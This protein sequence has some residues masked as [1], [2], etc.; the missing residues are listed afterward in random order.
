MLERLFEPRRVAVIG[1]SGRPGQVGTE[2]VRSLLAG[3]R[4]ISVVHP[5]EKTVLGVGVTENIEDLPGDVDLAVVAL[6]AGTAEEACVRAARRG[7]P[8]IVPV[9]GGFSETGETGRALERSLVNAVRAAGGRVL[10]PNTVGLWVPGRGGVDTLFV[11]H[12]RELIS[13]RGCVAFVSQSGSVGVEALGAAAV[14]GYG[15]RAFVSL[16]NKADLDES[17]F[18]AH[19]GDDPGCR[20]IALYLESFRDG[21]RFLDVAGAVSRK[22]PVVILKA[23]ATRAGAGAVA[24]HTGAL[25]GSPLVA[26]GAFRQARI[27]SVDGDEALLDGAKALALCP[28]P[29][30]PRAAFLTPAGGYGVLAADA[31]ESSEGEL[32]LARLSEDCRRRLRE[33]SFPY[34][35]VNNPVDLT[36]S[37]TSAMMVEALRILVA[38]PGV[39]LVLCAAF[40]APPGMSPDLVP[41]IAEVARSAKKPVL[42]LAMFGHET[43]ALCKRFTD[44]GVAAFP[45]LAR[46]VCAARLLVRR[47]KCFS[48]PADIKYGAPECG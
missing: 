41:G 1:A 30:G 35:A 25:S 48:G 42:V 46:A 23:G 47:G 27:L 11:Q 28:A 31:I 26:E 32:C 6:S 9:A 36:A 17:D 13:H 43:Q 4:P 22:K 20:G 14:T 5:R 33:A 16:G 38:D 2:V 37:A 7:V 18:V 3:G 19:F 10:G 12:E 8:F 39:D 45:S 44:V 24:S 15:L 40:L 29:A 21:R 34:A